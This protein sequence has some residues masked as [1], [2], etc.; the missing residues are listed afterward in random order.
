MTPSGGDDRIEQGQ[1]RFRA[2]GAVVALGGSNCVGQPGTQA[3]PLHGPVQ[4]SQPAEVRQC[5]PGEADAEISRS[6]SHRTE[7]LLTLIRK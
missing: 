3:D 5:S 4:Q 7:A 6:A 2:A 1:E